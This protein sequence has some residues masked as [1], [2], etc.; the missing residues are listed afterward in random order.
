MH[1]TTNWYLSSELVSLGCHTNYKI[2]QRRVIL[3]LLKRRVTINKMQFVIWIFV[4]YNCF[5]HLCSRIRK[6]DLYCQTDNSK[7]HLTYNRIIKIN[8]A[9]VKTII[10]FLQLYDI[11]IKLN[12]KCAKSDIPLCFYHLNKTLRCHFVANY[13]RL[14]SVYLSNWPP[15]IKQNSLQLRFT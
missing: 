5:R 13:I 8:I 10:Y 11:S 3:R 1:C 2:R 9:V 7:C 14:I 12:M 15:F 6:Y 4:I